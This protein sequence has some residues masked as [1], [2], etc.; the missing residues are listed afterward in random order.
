MPYGLNPALTVIPDTLKLAQAQ[1]LPLCESWDYEDWDEYDY[2]R[3]KSLKFRELQ[4]AR[5]REG[6]NAVSKECL[7]CPDF[8]KHVSDP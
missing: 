1:F 7:K 2:S 6:Q 3:I 5:M 8:L 4:D